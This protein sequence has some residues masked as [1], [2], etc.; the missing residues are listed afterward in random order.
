MAHIAWP[1]IRNIVDSGHPCP[2]GLIIGKLPDVTEMGH[3]VCV[4]AYQLVGHELTLWFDDPNSPGSDDVT[5][6]L[7]ISRTDQTIQ[8]ASNVNVP[9]VPI[10]F[11][12]QTYEQRIPVEGIPVR[13]ETSSAVA[14]TGEH[15]DVF[16]V[17]R[18][19]SVWSNWWDQNINDAK[20]NAPFQVAGPMLAEP[21]RLRIRQEPAAAVA[22][23]QPHLDVFWAGPDGSVR[24]AWWDQNVNGAAWN[25]PFDVAPAGT[26]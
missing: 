14:R 26:A 1:D 13:T 8:V 24:S 7:D 11:F 3:Q 22:R 25:A 19:G 15:L 4:Y 17:G 21:G 12:T 10:C 23:E 9:H 6:Q 18:D 20:W 2:I 16:W 5:M